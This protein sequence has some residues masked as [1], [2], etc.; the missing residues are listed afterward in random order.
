MTTGAQLLR[1]PAA[2]VVADVD[3]G[4]RPLALDEEP[5]LRVEVAL[6]CPVEV[7]VVLAEVG[8]GE[9]AE[10]N[11]VEP[12]QLGAVRG[13]L[14]CTAPVAGVEHL[15]EGALEVDRLRCRADRR[16]ALPTDPAFDRAEQA[17]PS[18]GRRGDRVEEARG[19]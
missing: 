2:V 6:E 12:P 14:E 8:E 16:P 5:A 3:R 15:A 4:G 13:R 1:E 11:A 19:P 9:R 10:A 7:E 17:G 18:R